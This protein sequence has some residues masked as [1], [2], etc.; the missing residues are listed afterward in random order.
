VEWVGIGVQRY[1]GSIRRNGDTDGLDFEILDG[2][3]L[4]GEISRVDPRFH[5]FLR[6]KA[7]QK[8]DSPE[9]NEQMEEKSFEHNRSLAGSYHP[10]LFNAL[11][12]GTTE[13][14]GSC[15]AKTPEEMLRIADELREAVKYMK[16]HIHVLENLVSYL[17]KKNAP[18]PGVNGM[19][20]DSRAAVAEA[21]NELKKLKELIQSP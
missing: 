9:E 11:R 4:E 10:K 18:D 16:S 12:R 13:A 21:E 6:E 15:L 8:L 7:F 1:F 14:K 2:I 20:R 19:L 5:A 17:E 3:H